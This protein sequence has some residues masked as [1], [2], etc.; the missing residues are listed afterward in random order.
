MTCKSRRAG[1]DSIHASGAWSWAMSTNHSGVTTPEA[2]SR[3]FG[4]VVRVR[5][6]RVGATQTELADFLG[7]AQ[8]SLSRR[9]RPSPGQG[10][11][12]DEAY[13][14]ADFLGTSALDLLGEAHTLLKE[15]AA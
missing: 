13:D 1:L 5:L 2:F 9:L 7:M 12:L 8:S 15:G 3:A 6:W 10:F 4:E 11:T 14:V